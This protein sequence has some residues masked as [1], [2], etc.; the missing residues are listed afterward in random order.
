MT[1]FENMVEFDIFY[2]DPKMCFRN[3]RTSLQDWRKTETIRDKKYKEKLKVQ[4]DNLAL[5]RRKHGVA[6]KEKSDNQLE[7]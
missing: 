1:N 7:N 6:H 4:Q 5:L 2:R 3:L